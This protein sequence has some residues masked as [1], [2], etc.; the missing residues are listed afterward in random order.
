MNAVEDY[1]RKWANK[2]GVDVS[3]LSEWVNAIRH[4]V[5]SVVYCLRNY[6]STRSKSVFDNKEIATKLADIHDQYVVV[7][8][9]KASNNVVFVCIQYIQCLIK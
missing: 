7:P 9:D 5:I 3:A 8:A 2:E 4:L 6:M 1:S